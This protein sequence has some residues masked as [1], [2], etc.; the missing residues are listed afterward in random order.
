[1]ETQN[2]Y[3]IFLWVNLL[4]V[5]HFED[6]GETGR[7][8]LRCCEDWRWMELCRIGSSDGILRWCYR[9]HRF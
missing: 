3:R 5:A 9:I 8:A 6:R 1:M 4:E 2:G 7:L